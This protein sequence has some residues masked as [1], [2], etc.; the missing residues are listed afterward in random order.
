MIF[1]FIKQTH[2]Q[3]SAIFEKTKMDIYIFVFYHNHAPEPTISRVVVVGTINAIGSDANVPGDN[4]ARG[5]ARSA[6]APQRLWFKWQRRL[7]DLSSFSRTHWF[8]SHITDNCWMLW[9]LS[10]LASGEEPLECVDTT[11]PIWF[12][13]KWYPGISL[14]GIDSCVLPADAMSIFKGLSGELLFVPVGLPL[15]R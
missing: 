2:G 8:F 6:A 4:W 3:F 15:C 7:G 10:S 14:T 13:G 1:F 9:I 12:W 5:S 11:A